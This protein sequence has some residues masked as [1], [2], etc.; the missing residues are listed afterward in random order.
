MHKIDGNEK[1][2]ECELMERNK[3]LMCSS[4]MDFASK[5]R[6]NL[7]CLPKCTCKTWLLWQ[8][9]SHFPAFSCPSETHRFSSAIIGGSDL[10]WVAF[11]DSNSW[12]SWKK[13]SRT[14]TTNWMETQDKSLEGCWCQAKKAEL[15]WIIDG[16]VNILREKERARVQITQCTTNYVPVLIVSYRL[17]RLVQAQLRTNHHYSLMQSPELNLL[18]EGAQ[19]PPTKK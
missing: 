8:G 13:L 14:P 15:W 7:V 3:V 2:G 11:V 12:R 6:A 1:L 18:V 16:K 10:L 5:S 17:N 4:G 19:V 9:G